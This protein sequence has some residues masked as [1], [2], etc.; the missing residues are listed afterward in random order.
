MAYVGKS[1]NFQSME[2]TKSDSGATV[3]S[4]VTNSSNTASSNA[5]HTI[6]VAGTSAGDA[7]Y[8]AVVSGATTWSWGVDNSA[9]DAWVLAASAALGT[10]NAVSISTAG[11]MTVT[12]AITSNGN[13]VITAA[14]TLDDLS[15]TTSAELASVI[16]DETGSGALVFATSPTLVTPALGTP[17][18]G[19]LTNCTGLPISTGV[20]G[21][22]SGVATFLATPSSANLA[23]ALTDETGSGSAVFATSP[24]ITT[25]AFSGNFTATNNQN[26]TSQWSWSNTDNTDSSSRALLSITGGTVIGNI[27]S[28]ATA[29]FYMGSN[30]SHD[31][32]LIAGGS[33]V[34]R[35][36]ATTNRV[37]IGTSSPSVRFEVSVPGDQAGRFNRTSNDGDVIGILQDGTQ[38]GSISVS[39][40]TVSYN[41][42]LGSHPSQFV[43][44][45]YSI[46]TEDMVA[47]RDDETG[48]PT[49]CAP[50]QIQKGTVVCAID[51]LVDPEII[52]D[53]ERH[54]KVKIS[55][56]ANDK[57]VYGVYFYEK[58][59]D[60]QWGHMIAAV[61]N[62][63][64]RTNLEN[65]AIQVG[66]L[67]CTSSTPGVAM[68][69]SDNIVRSKTL[70]RARQSLSSLP[71]GETEA[72]IAVSLMAG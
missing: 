26:A 48:I 50:Q 22:G 4:T 70:G 33:E 45:E 3:S 54:P 28:I 18:S 42:F 2:I 32:I 27:N 12:G 31:T 55:D 53:L 68:K 24:T 23:S 64:V 15:A 30:S 43:E 58:C 6:T 35:L 21:L 52:S 8:S 39:G 16:S 67:L 49:R 38:E 47:T 66:D 7:Y 36:K 29:G 10:S 60:E 41:A 17:A 20:S 57:S 9:S 59:H 56:T 65:G 71:E 69:Q 72:T 63:V 14:N 13:N 34:A 51:E 1:P 37:G 44:A 61:G 19:T 46:A 11:A 5:A 40:T 25:P 62:F